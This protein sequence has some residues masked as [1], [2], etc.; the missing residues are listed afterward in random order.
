M[1]VIKQLGSEGKTGNWFR[2]KRL[3]TKQ[4]W[5]KVVYRLLQ[6]FIRRFLT[7]ECKDVFDL[8]TFLMSKCKALCKVETSIAKYLPD[9]SYH[10]LILESTCDLLSVFWK[11][12]LI[13]LLT[14]SGWNTMAMGP[15]P[16][17]QRS[18]ISLKLV[19]GWSRSGHC[20][21]IFGCKKIQRFKKCKM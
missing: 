19:I 1:V 9:S 3:F 11:R 7:I 20:N 21:S 8:K 2:Y 12:A 16:L 14:S 6:N 18:S 13:S 17:L 10:N 4:K 5:K 15:F